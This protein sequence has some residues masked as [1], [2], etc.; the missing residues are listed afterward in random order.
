MS[1]PQS[2][3][4]SDSFGVLRSLL[5]GSFVA[6][7]LSGQ[8]A[9]DASAFGPATADPVVISGSWTLACSGPASFDFGPREVVFAPGAVVF[10]DGCTLTA[11]RFVVSAG[12]TIGSG[13]VVLHTSH[14]GSAHDGAVVV[15]GTI[16]ASGNFVT[17]GLPI[18][19]SASGTITVLGSGVVRSRAGTDV[20]LSGGSILLESVGDLLIDSG[21]APIDTGSPSPGGSGGDVTVRSTAGA[22][23]LRRPILTGAFTFSGAV[24]LAARF[25]L[26]IA[27]AV[28]ASADPVFGYDPGAAGAIVATSTLGA[29]HVTAPLAANGGGPVGVAASITLS[30]AGAVHVTAPLSSVGINARLIGVNAGEAVLMTGAVDGHGLD[31]VFD[32]AGGRG[33]AFT[34]QS[35]TSV[36]IPGAIDVRGGSGSEGFGPG[37]FVHV[38]SAG[39]IALEAITT[40]G[41]PAGN[42]TIQSGETMQ[43]GPISAKSVSDLPGVGGSILV[44]SGRDALLGFISVR[45]SSQP[46]TVVL[47]AARDLSSDGVDMGSDVPLAAAPLTYLSA[48]AGRVLEAAGPITYPGIAE[49]PTTDSVRLTACRIRLNG[50]IGSSSPGVAGGRLRF[51][52]YDRWTTDSAIDAAPNG[53][54]QLTTRLPDPFSPVYEAGAV[55]TPPLA[56]VHD[57]TSAPCLAIGR[58]SLSAPSAVPAGGVYELVLVGRPN[59]GVLV[60]VGL[61]SAQLPLGPLGYTQIDLFAAIPLADPGLLGPALPGSM[62]AADGRWTFSATIPSPLAGLQ[63]R[64]EAFVFADSALNGSFDQPKATTTLVTAPSP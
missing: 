48:T 61:Q 41:R 53:S 60:A 27:G 42:I 21:A 64:A 22:T 39:P 30:A 58:A 51:T 46:G 24:T 52:A 15:A 23:D 59:R 5:L 54:V 49:P 3:R 26:T 50:P 17:D 44:D 1:G 9:S 40:D 57:P 28:D 38:Q 13:G 56:V 2:L 33:A 36:T 32:M 31:G 29:L 45:A 6:T 35:P 63:I 20:F 4:L 18:S 7:A 8:T 10:T 11:A 16:D 37:G 62:T 19:V 55:V 47:H 43:T 34:A 25:D 12:A 14:A